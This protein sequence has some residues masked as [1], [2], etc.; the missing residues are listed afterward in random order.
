MSD[1]TPVSPVNGKK[2]ELTVSAAAKEVNEEPVEL[3]S[4]P[5]DPEEISRRRSSKAD[6]LASLSPAE[7]EM[8]NNAISQRQGDPAVLVSCNYPPG[9][10]EMCRSS[11]GALFVKRVRRNLYVAKTASHAG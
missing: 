3:D 5:I 10:L 8:R 1:D 7:R 11:A 2:P 9:D 6:T 4:I